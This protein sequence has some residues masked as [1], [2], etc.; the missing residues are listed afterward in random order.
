MAHML[1]SS[2]NAIYYLALLV[3]F[4][5]IHIKSSNIHA[6]SKHFLYWIYLLGD[7]AKSTYYFGRSMPQ[8]LVDREATLFQ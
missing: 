2:S 6:T 8:I 7:F 1:A 4:K 5:V 3:H